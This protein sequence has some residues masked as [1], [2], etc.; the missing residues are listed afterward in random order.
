MLTLGGLAVLEL[1][2]YMMTR[3]GL[4]LPVTVLAAALVLLV[5]AVLRVSYIEVGRGWGFVSHAAYAIGVIWALSQA[6]RYLTSL[7]PIYSDAGVGT[8]PGVM[9]VMAIVLGLPFG[10]MV[11]PLFEGIAMIQRSGWRRWRRQ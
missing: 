5:F 1:A 3:P 11:H 8:V 4:N 7:T 6:P 10:L 9:L 2:I